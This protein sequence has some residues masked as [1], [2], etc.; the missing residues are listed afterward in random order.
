[1]L[2]Q[3][4]LGLWTECDLMGHVVVVLLPRSFGEEL[5]WSKT[6]LRWI[7]LKNH[8]IWPFILSSAPSE[9]RLPTF[10][11]CSSEEAL[12]FRCKWI[13]VLVGAGGAAG[14]IARDHAGGWV[15]CGTVK[16]LLRSSD[17]HGLCTQLIF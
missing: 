15:C 12:D 7:V 10:D 9:P 13:R 3:T 11:L 6:N 14:S 1:M 2:T 8:D 16:W 5:I 17:Q 4:D